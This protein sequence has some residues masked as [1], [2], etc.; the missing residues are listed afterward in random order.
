[1][2]RASWVEL[3]GLPAEVTSSVT[4]ARVNGDGLW[5]QI[6]AAN[7]SVRDACRRFEDALEDASVI[8]NASRPHVQLALTAWFGAGNERVFPGRAGWL[9]FPPDVHYVTGAGFLE[10]RVL[11]RRA[12]SSAVAG[13]A[14]QPDPRAAILAFKRD[15]ER[16]RHLADRGADTRQADDPSGKAVA[17]LRR[18][19]RTSGEPVLLLARRTVAPRRRPGLR[20][21]GRAHRECGLVERASDTSRPTR[22]GVPRR[23][24]RLRCV[25]PSTCAPTWRCTPCR[26]PATSPSLESSRS[27]GMSA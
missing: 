7:N 11:E 15:L 5:R 10:P 27:S 4:A 13:N 18:G 8:G 20:S 25:W 12:R 19:E 1:M 9:F 14:I 23:C 21:S 26:L 24:S 22:T 6:V 17:P 2:R 16:A 3:R